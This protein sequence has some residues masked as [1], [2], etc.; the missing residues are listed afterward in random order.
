MILNKFKKR[1]SKMVK[2][3]ETLE[4]E[5]DKKA[6]YSMIM[7]AI[8]GAAIAFYIA[9]NTDG[10]IFRVYI[11]NSLF[12]I[13]MPVELLVLFLIFVLEGIVV[14]ILEWQYEQLRGNKK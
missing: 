8:L 6:E 4:A 5:L 9:W 3:Y 12:L 14:T 2:S 10:G 11:N 13:D 7:A 1:H